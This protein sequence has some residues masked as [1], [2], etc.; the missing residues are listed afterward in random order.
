MTDSGADIG[1][2][3][4]PAPRARRRTWGRRSLWALL[5]LVGLWVAVD[6][7]EIVR[8]RLVLR[9]LQ[10]RGETLVLT[11]FAPPPMRPEDNAAPLLMEAGSEVTRVWNGLAA[12][13][14]EQARKGGG[15]EWLR[16][17]IERA[18]IAFYKSLRKRSSAPERA[19]GPVHVYREHTE[20][21]QAL[22]T[23]MAPALETA[24]RA[25]ERPAC[26]F[27]LVYED[28][29]RMELPRL[30]MQRGLAR[31]YGLR[32]VDRAAAGNA[33]GAAADCHAILRLAQAL[34]GEPILVS[35]LVRT[36]ID[37]FA[38]DAMATVADVAPLLPETHERFA[39]ALAD[40]A[41]RMDFPRTMRME[42]AQMYH[43]LRT[44]GS[45]Y[46][47]SV[48][49]LAP[50]LT[51]AWQRIALT[52]LTEYINALP[53]PYAQARARMD[54]VSRG[55]TEGH[56]LTS[57]RRS[58]PRQVLPALANALDAHLRGIAKLRTASIGFRVHATLARG[59]APPDS[60][61]GIPLPTRTDPFAEADLRL[62]RTEDA[63]LVY[64]VGV[65]GRDDGGV[66]EKHNRDRSPDIKDDIVFRVPLR[67][68][69]E[70]RE[71]VVDATAS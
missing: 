67:Q 58:V 59:E 27:D 47:R 15:A 55:L 7:M 12:Y 21:L 9:E 14:T 71:P 26:R 13:A 52:T 44:S 61:A 19:E 40:E 68:A 1:A 35:Q 45:G 16:H 50:W 30:A 25:L 62:T 60:L 56:V 8:L 4:P 11:D 22:L 23:I 6:L 17:P 29:Y 70:S 5:I 39:D 43:A 33:E 42:R 32:A 63:I 31:L 49:W 48:N 51:R 34:E 24:D 38:I 10:A 18:S 66:F 2:P 37:G 69:S 3:T 64:A 46:P 20:E 36:A 28:G 65:N 53:L 54:E 41:E 57:V